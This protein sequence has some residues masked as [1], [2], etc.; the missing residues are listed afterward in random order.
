MTDSATVDVDVDVDAVVAE[1]DR[2]ARELLPAD[3]VAAVD[4]DDPA[5]LATIRSNFDS[6]R[7]G[8]TS[9]TQGT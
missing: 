7:G 9:R 8:C 1:V 5:T 3:W 6:P 2:F 4:R